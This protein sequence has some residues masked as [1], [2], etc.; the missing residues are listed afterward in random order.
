MLRFSAHTA[1]H[2][3]DEAIDWLI[4]SIDEGLTQDIWF[5]RSGA[6]LDTLRAHPRF[7]EVLAKLDA[8]EV[9]H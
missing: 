7:A 3:D 2:E 1:L 8:S 9:T 4:R 6:L 5:I